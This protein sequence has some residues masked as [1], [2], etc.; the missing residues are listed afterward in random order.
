MA[1]EDNLAQLFTCMCWDR[2]QLPSQLPC[3]SY[4]C[5]ECPGGQASTCQQGVPCRPCHQQP[6]S[7]GWPESAGCAQPH[8][9]LTASHLET[10]E[11]TEGGGR[12]HS[13]LVPGSN[14]PQHQPFQMVLHN[15]NACMV[16]IRSFNSAWGKERLWL[17]KLE[18]LNTA[19]SESKQTQWWVM[20]GNDLVRGQTSSGVLQTPQPGRNYCSRL[21]YQH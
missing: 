21:N 7:C 8:P 6:G 19:I 13:S 17:G 18:I 11:R 3:K 5:K 4:L 12:A 20:A 16:L 15:S 2:L 10:R 14:F 1:Q 9:S